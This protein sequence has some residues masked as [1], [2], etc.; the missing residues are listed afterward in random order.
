LENVFSTPPEA[1]PSSDGFNPFD[2]P[3]D[4]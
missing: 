3:S 4:N 2:L 1:T